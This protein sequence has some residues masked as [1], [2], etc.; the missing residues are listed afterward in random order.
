MT[1]QIC[2]FI[3]RNSNR[4]RRKFQFLIEINIKEF[5]STRSLN[6]F[7]LITT[8]Q[9]RHCYIVA[10]QYRYVTCLLYLQGSNYYFI[11]R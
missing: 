11:S 10:I 2:F 3:P 8:L 1:I 9:L 7:S 5:K 6:I 4:S